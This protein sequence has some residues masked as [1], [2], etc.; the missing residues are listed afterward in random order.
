M[1]QRVIRALKAKHR[2]QAVRK[3]VP[4]LDKKEPIPKIIILSVAITWGKAWNA[5]S[6]NTFTNCSKKAGFPEK[7]MER[8]LNDEDNPFAALDDIKE[9]SVQT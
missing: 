5:A 3:P 8:L 9:D 2:L 4:A 6:N 1:D 7:E